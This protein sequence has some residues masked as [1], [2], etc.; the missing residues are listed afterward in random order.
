M[1]AAWELA[2]LGRMR[3]VYG[4]RLSVF[5]VYAAEIMMYAALELT[6]GPSTFFDLAPSLTATIV[7]FAGP[8]IVTLASIP[9]YRSAAAMELAVLAEGGIRPFFLSRI[10]AAAVHLAMLFAML[11]PLYVM[12]QAPVLESAW[13]LLY[14]FLQSVTAA[15]AIILLLW[16]ILAAPGRARVWLPPCACLVACYIPWMWRAAWPQCLA[17]AAIAGIIALCLYYA[18]E[19]VEP[20]SLRPSRRRP[21]NGDP[22]GT[23]LGGGQPLIPLGAA[24]HPY[25]R[26]FLATVVCLAIGFTCIGGLFPALPFVLFLVMFHA[27]RF[28][29]GME[30]DDLRLAGYPPARVARRLFGRY[31]VRTAPLIAAGVAAEIGVHF[32]YEIGNDSLPTA[33]A[34]AAE[35][36]MLLADWLFAVA[37]A[38]A[39]TVKFDNVA[40]R[41]AHAVIGLIV[42]RGLYFSFV[43]VLVGT[44]VALILFGASGQ[45]ITQWHDH[46]N[47]L[48]A[49]PLLLLF[50]LRYWGMFA[51]SLNTYWDTGEFAKPKP[52]PARTAPPSLPQ[53]ARP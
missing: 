11:I 32:I 1:T 20:R 12:A 44:L 14:A 48:I 46:I 40:S 9:Y 21:G 47:A 3:W 10:A 31:L 38:L 36:A 52:A 49:P 18:P 33:A 53:G 8:V 39:I 29:G 45:G 17:L 37:M 23:L 6:I 7:T 43:Q 16:T 51:K 50:A 35:I 19:S 4:F 2:R 26:L 13:D 25:A 28:I 30:F 22:L 15:A 34:F 5:A 24:L 42:V 27:G 41:V